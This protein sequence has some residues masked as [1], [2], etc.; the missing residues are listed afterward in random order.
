MKNDYLELSTVNRKIPSSLVQSSKTLT[1][2]S[3]QRHSLPADS[4]QALAGP[5]HQQSHSASF[6]APLSSPLAHTLTDSRRHPLVGSLFASHYH[7]SLACSSPAFLSPMHSRFL[8]LTW[9]LRG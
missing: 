6:P 1:T 5:A 4:L 8:G 7:H 9:W 3:L 2:G